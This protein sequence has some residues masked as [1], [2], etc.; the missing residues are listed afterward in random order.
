[1]GRG[2]SDR[3]GAVHI[4]VFK[5]STGRFFVQLS[6]VV[7]LLRSILFWCSPPSINFRPADV[8]EIA[9]EFVARV[10]I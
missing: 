3:G 8:P 9:A 6:L 7:A 5:G 10:E 4:L 1:M 2:S